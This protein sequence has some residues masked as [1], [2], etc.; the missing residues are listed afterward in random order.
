MDVDPPAQH[1]ELKMSAPPPVGSEEEEAIFGSYYEWIDEEQLDLIL[2]NAHG[3]CPH[4][5][6][7]DARKAAQY[8]SF[9]ASRDVANEYWLPELGAGNCGRLIVAAEAVRGARDRIGQAPRPKTWD[10]KSRTVALLASEK[11]VRRN[12]EVLNVADVAVGFD[13]HYYPFGDWSAR[14]ICGF[15]FPDLDSAQ[16]AAKRVSRVLEQC[17][18]RAAKEACDELRLMAR[19]LGGQVV[20]ISSCHGSDCSTLAWQ[21]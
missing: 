13:T 6:R 10:G 21:F 19:K 1:H 15:R 17:G 4:V 14:L 18:G 16:R 20:D 2:G 9:L 8:V 12:I 5:T 11:D 3:Q 7:A